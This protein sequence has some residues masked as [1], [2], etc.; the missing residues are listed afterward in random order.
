MHLIHLKEVSPEQDCATLYATDQTEIKL[1]FS[2]DF[3]MMC[4]L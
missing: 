4:A 1:N 3:K 2:K